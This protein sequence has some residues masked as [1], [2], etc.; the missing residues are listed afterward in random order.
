MPVYDGNGTRL[1]NLQDGDSNL[2]ANGWY[3]GGGSYE[4]VYSP[5]T[6]YGMAAGATA[7]SARL[8]AFELNPFSATVVDTITSFPGVANIIRVTGAGLAFLGETL[9]CAFRVLINNPNGN[10]FRRYALYT[11]NT[12]TGALSFVGVRSIAAY[13]LQNAGG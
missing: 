13:V 11:V 4:L 3:T 6:L 10:D 2:L 5:G 9:Y 12:S 7:R 8:Y 1:I